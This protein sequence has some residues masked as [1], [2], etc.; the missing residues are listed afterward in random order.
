[1]LG[2]PLGFVL[3]VSFQNCTFDDLGLNQFKVNSG[4][5]LAEG[6]KVDLSSEGNGGSY[7]GKIDA[8]ARL[9]PGF[10]CDGKSAAFATFQKGPDFATLYSGCNEK[11]EIPLK[12]V[13]F[14][15]LSD[16]Y[17]GYK[18]GLFSYSKDLQGDLKKGAFTE[19][20][21][22]ALVN[23]NDNT[24]SPQF[25]IGIHW[26]QEGNVA[27]S[28]F[29]TAKDKPVTQTSVV[30]RID[31]EKVHYYAPNSSLAIQFLSQIPGTQKF[32]G[33]FQGVLGGS[34]VTLPVQC[35]LG[36]QFD[37]VAPQLSYQENFQTLIQGKPFVKISPTLNKAKGQFS[38]S[39]ELPSGLIFNSTTGEI[40]GVPTTLQA[41][42]K[43]RVTVLLDFGEVSRTISIGV[44]TEMSVDPSCA[45]DAC[46]LLKS[47]ERANA[48]APVPAVINFAGSQI[49]SGA[50]VSISGDVEIRGSSAVF[51]ARGLSRH[52][53][54][55]PKGT[56]SL[57]GI[58]LKNG[59]ADAGGS[60]F[61]ES[62]TLNIKRSR[63][64]NNQATAQNYGSGGAVLVRQ[65]FLSVTDSLF[66]N[67]KTSMNGGNLFGGA[68][69]AEN[70]LGL[71]IA[72]SE[73]RGNFSAGGGAIY[74]HNA[75]AEVSEMTDLIVTGNS[76]FFGAGID[77]RSGM[78]MIKNSSFE[79]N[80]ALNEGGGLRV[81]W[82]N[83]VWLD[84]SRFFTNSA[85]KGSA[86]SYNFFA[87]HTQFYILNSEVRDN[88]MNPRTLRNYP[89]IRGSALN[90]DGPVVIRSSVIANALSRTEATGGFANCSATYS[91]NLFNT[92]VFLGENIFNDSSCENRVN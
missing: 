4:E 69:S 35:R 44:G 87:E 36:G 16:N 75:S 45:L 71:L 9:V 34:I 15:R 80:N 37:P 26:E 43:Y 49:W 39:P 41:R 12:D 56:L 68:I 30:R 40:S 85:D 83:R 57:A 77:L 65:G 27:L 51:D 28:R 90:L 31:I 62:A 61:A 3:L 18:D 52:F 23:E 29:Y 17:A 82:T 84:N 25:E 79:S 55:K 91:G 1:L 33:V 21:C 76:A 19:A 64:E 74:L 14:S 11:S 5:G 54:V 24:S 13:E 46:S 63:F 7:D 92:I 70:S 2:I 81:F 58:T 67:N 72:R 60:I 73:F 88:V 8:F 53:S 78:V 32:P 38:I 89:M 86:I 66:L 6:L 20:W 22:Q 42:Q 50:E 59:V 47:I 10:T 48:Q